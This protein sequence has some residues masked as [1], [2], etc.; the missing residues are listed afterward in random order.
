MTYFKLSAKAML[1]H[2]MLHPHK[3]IWNLLMLS[4]IS[5][6][7]VNGALVGCSDGHCLSVAD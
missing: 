2:E 4:Y 6:D 3:I 7:V 1:K 5:A